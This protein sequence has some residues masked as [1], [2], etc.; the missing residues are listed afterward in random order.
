MTAIC[1]AG[2][3]A[4]QR[5]L[6]VDHDQHQPPPQQ[7]GHQHFNPEDDDS[8]RRRS[9]VVVIEANI[10][11]DGSSRIAEQAWL[12]NGEDDDDDGQTEYADH[13]TETG[14]RYDLDPKQ[15]GEQ[16]AKQKVYVGDLV[17]ESDGEM[18]ETTG[19]F[20]VDVDATTATTTT[21]TSRIQVE[22][23]GDEFNVN[24][25]E[26]DDDDDDDRR[27]GILLFSIRIF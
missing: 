22:V 15:D 18:S 23:D 24:N 7:I 26:D 13:D 16:G 1:G 3:D 11:E 6:V 8:L 10:D 5:K 27:L 4:E 19:G 2:S 17:V 9:E 12:E 20:V 21:I 25:D 14:N